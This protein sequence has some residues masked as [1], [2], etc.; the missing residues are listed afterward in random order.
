MTSLITF[1]CSVF[2]LFRFWSYSYVLW[3]TWTT[4]DFEL[5][6]IGAG[7]V[8]V[9]NVGKYKKMEI[10]ALPVRIPLCGVFTDS[11]LFI[12]NIIQVVLYYA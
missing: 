6:S 3:W 4:I 12:D 5:G 8:E 11:L 10:N 1:P 9:C 7:R 2:Y